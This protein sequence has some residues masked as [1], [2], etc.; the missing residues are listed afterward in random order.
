MSTHQ[1]N[2]TSP[3]VPGP[4]K[5]GPNTK[6]A[7]IGAGV[8]GITTAAYLLKNGVDVTVFERSGLTSGV[9]HYDSKAPNSPSYPSVAPSA[10]DY[11]ISKL[12]Q[13]LPTK[14]PAA[15]QNG[16]HTHPL[17]SD[18]AE[19]RRIAFSP[20]G[21]AY[22]GLR[23]NVPTTL[24]YSSLGPWPQGTEDITG[25]KQIKSYLQGLSTQH[26]VDDVTVFHTRVD[27]ARKSDDGK[28][29][30]LRTVTLLKGD[31]SPR[32]LERT[33]QFDALVI[34][35]GH[36]NL[37]RIPDTPGLSEWK[38]RYGDRILHTKEYRHPEAFKDKTVLVIGGGASAMDVCRES[39]ATAKK[40]LQSTRGGEF[41]LPKSMLPPSIEHLGGIE[42]FE[43]DAEVT[44]TSELDPAA[45]IQGKIVLADGQVVRD[46]DYVVLATGYLTS[47]PFFPQ[48]HADSTDIDAVTPDI[49]V[50]SE[51]NMVHH[52]HKDIFYIEDPSLSFIGVP[53]YTATFSLF[54][55]QAQAL[56]RLY[57]GKTTLPSREAMRADYEKRV[58]AT[59][60]GRGFHSLAVDGAEPDYIKDLFAWA[61][62]SLVDDKTEPLKGHTDQWLETYWEARE[63]RKKLRESTGN[64]PEAN[65]P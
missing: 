6:V 22:A 40:V 56:A 26:G 5:F 8:S 64:H 4:N 59:G 57:S 16:D 45:P 32:V 53:Y 24:L 60:R 37:P 43:L 41:D 18:D 39:T 42:K 51:G 9:W 50:T 30:N 14:A 58:A 61:N 11:E 7:V 2:G 28:H 19:A 15:S 38:A 36:Y 63:T 48:Y 54:D 47:Y 13:F 55:F 21:P 35:S 3:A 49:L 62:G 27:D 20:P 65:W 23:N 29:W 33:W 46:I 25:H 1:T 31:G 52:L 34:A 10:G 12:G 17:D 44:K